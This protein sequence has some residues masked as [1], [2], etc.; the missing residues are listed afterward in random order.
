MSVWLIDT[1]LYT[2]LLIGLV[3][4]LRRPVARLFGPQMAY[5][6]W[7]LPLVRLLLPPVVLPATMAERAEPT[8][9]PTEVPLVAAPAAAG[10]PWQEMLVSLWLG[11]ALAFLLWRVVEYRRMRRIMLRGARPMGDSGPIRLVE[12]P[13]VGSPV[14]FGLRDKVVALP[15]R[16]MALADR[17]ARDMAIAHELE[18]H[19]GRDLLVNL[20]AQLLLAVHWFNPIAWLGWRAMRRDQEAACD[21]R[22]VAGRD[23]TERA[24]YA[25]VIAGFAMGPRALRQAPLAC[26]MLGEKSI[27]YRLRSLARDDISSPRR[28]AGRCLLLIAALALPL[29]ASVTYAAAQ[30]P[31]VPQP[32]APPAAPAAPV[33]PAPPAPPAEP[34]VLHH[35][36]EPAVAAEWDRV[37]AQ[38][39]EDHRQ[40][41]ADAAEAHPRAGGAYS[42]AGGARAIATAE[43]AAAVAD[44]S[45]AYARSTVGN[46][47][48]VAMQGSSGLS[49]CITTG[50]EAACEHYANTVAISALRGARAAIAGNSAIPAD[51]RANI[52]RDLDGEIAN[53]S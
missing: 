31:A 2:G 45:V 28:W 13:A 48:A 27:I 42:G 7:A 20:L 47:V 38:A 17:T 4:L 34:P 36:A 25:E 35:A 51:V 26:P 8:V 46:Q 5:A 24:R 41:A 12:T 32:P 14:A 39:E 43:P 44:R 50:G 15:P 16:F 11:G 37:A 23:R 3:L 19:R 18:H 21:A 6:L 33:P 22:V 10:W 29:T 40:A 1:L 9:M 30:L 52:L 53:Q 49:A